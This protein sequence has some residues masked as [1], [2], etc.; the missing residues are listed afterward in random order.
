[1][2]R[3]VKRSVKKIDEMNRRDFSFSREIKFKTES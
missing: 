3:T 1:M 2:G